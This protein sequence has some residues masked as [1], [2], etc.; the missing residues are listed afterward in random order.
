MVRWSAVLFCS[1][2]IVSCEGMA[3]LVVQLVCVDVS[4]D[5]PAANAATDCRCRQRKTAIGECYY[6]DC[7]L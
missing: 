3:A 6:V 7:S 4:S 5:C 2:V 1:C